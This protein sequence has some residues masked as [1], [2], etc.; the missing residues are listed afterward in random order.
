MIIVRLQGGLGN[1]MFQYALG[2]VLALK[3]NT[4]LGMDLAFLLDRTPAP[5]IT[6]RDYNLGDFNI[7]ATIVPQKDIPFFYRKH[8]LGFFMRYLDFLRRKFIPSPGKEKKAYNFDSTIL[9][10]GSNSYLEGW[11]QNPNYFSEFQE[12]IRNDFTLKHTSEKVAQRISEIKSKN[13]VCVHIR[14]GDYVSGDY[15]GRS[16]YPVM[17]EVYY[18][19]TLNLISEKDTIDCV[20]V[21]DRDDIEW[22]KKNVQ[23]DYPVVYIEND[24]TVAECVTLMSS[25]KHFVM[26]NSSLSWW[27]AWLGTSPEKIVVAPKKWLTRDSV[28]KN[29]ADLLPDEW[30]KM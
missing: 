26:A 29:T 16:Y 7:K 11:W 19:N 24:I 8:R 13:S 3:N 2:R 6:F 21:F 1:Q 27:A 9:S 18:K 15:L 28:N 10:L 14:R 5:G 30:I 17:D 4:E 20:Y 12:I 23:F 22:C 25:C